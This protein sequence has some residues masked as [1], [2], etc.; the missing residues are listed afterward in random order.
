[1]KLEK[2][3][4]ETINIDDLIFNIKSNNIIPPSSKEKKEIQKQTVY[5]VNNN[6]FIA[7]LN[8]LLIAIVYDYKNT[9]ITIKRKGIFRYSNY[10]GRKNIISALNVKLLKINKELNFL[11]ETEKIYIESVINLCNLT[12]T[13]RNLHL[14]LHKLIKKFRKNYK[15]ESI[16]KTLLA[17]SEYLFLS[18]HIPETK[19]N[20]LLISNRSKEEIISAVSYLIH[21][22]T[23]TYEIKSEEK[24]FIS[25]KYI[26]T[27]EIDKII[28]FTCN[29]IDFKE[30]EILIEHFNYKCTFHNEKI[31]LSPP[32]IDFAK[33]IDF[34]YI[35]Y[36]IQ[37]IND[38][39]QI[40]NDIENIELTSLYSIIS[41]II[42]DKKLAV[43][44]KINNSTNN[45]YRLEIPEPL[46][47]YL[48]EKIFKRNELFQE[49]I[50]QLSKAFKEQMLTLDFL[51]STKIK[52]DLTIL[53][54]IKI[55]RVFYF[56]SSLFPKQIYKLEKE[57]CTPALL[58]SI[59]PI[60][61]EEAIFSLL[62]KLTSNKN[63]ESFIDILYWEQG[64]ETIYDMQY[65]PFL[66]INNHFMIPLSI[67][68]H[69]NTYRN[70]Y[71]SEYK[72]NNQQLASD[73]QIDLL[74]QKL[75]ETFESS[76][77]S[78]YSETKIPNSDID[79]FVIYDNVLFIFECK[80][81]LH[82]TNI[83][84]LRTTYDYI[85]KAEKQLDN[86]VELFNN[87]KLIN[88]LERKHSIDLKEIKTLIPVIITSNRLF[89]GNSFK[90][91]IRYISEVANYIKTGVIRTEKE[92]FSLW[93]NT[94]ISIDDLL[95]YFSITS[96]LVKFQYESLSSK[97]IEYKLSQPPILID[98]YFLNFEYSRI[99]LNEYTSKLNKKTRNANTG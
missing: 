9:F 49:E 81:S 64:V 76:N 98:K 73:G 40:K 89:N 2:K 15:K 1:M 21:I 5:F 7:S 26:I 51:K 59:I 96:D 77:I 65:H 86:V 45:R 35:K 62:E 41:E 93:K 88:L 6:K 13:Y 56:L 3:I 12:Y 27:Q 19:A 54:Y 47:H 58:N 16:I 94:K 92:E 17:Y 63:I 61:K 95:E 4:L 44:K 53:E 43:L 57:A 33:S 34:G 29:I 48:N 32:S 99:K 80:Q 82:P 31:K 10:I 36:Q 30:F 75:H 25:D 23:D 52:D 78:C 38:T 37:G 83:Y 22:I 42:N 28:I 84:D 46:I 18:N 74:V 60:F 91:P 66:Y 70:L 90:Y 20:P 8:Y 97:T 24:L 87:N 39:I 68:A 79:L 85:K 71:A 67:F 69:S 14:V 55:K 50:I 11:K 72:R